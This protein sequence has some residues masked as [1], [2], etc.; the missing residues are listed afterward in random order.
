MGMQDIARLAARNSLLNPPLG[1]QTAEMGIKFEL[2]YIRFTTYHRRCELGLIKFLV[3]TRFPETMGTEWV[4]YD[5]RCGVCPLTSK[6]FM[7][8]G[9]TREI[10]RHTAMWWVTYLER[11]VPSVGDCPCEELFDEKQEIWDSI[12]RTLAKDCPICHEAAR[13]EFPLFR[14]KLQVAI[15][16]IINNVGIHF[17]DRD[18][19]Q[20]AN[21]R[22]NRSN[23]RFNRDIRRLSF[24]A[25]CL[26]RPVSHIY[27][28]SSSH[29]F[30]SLTISA[31]L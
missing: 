19:C 14:E 3:T 18:V 22:S 8:P 20:G 11:I 21:S 4:W 15:T 9:E 5:T 25:T 31:S 12:L 7:V 6:R 16:K 2:D 26:D 27:L 28:A 30:S 23:W 10:T 13:K 24:V 29:L 17:V 1:T